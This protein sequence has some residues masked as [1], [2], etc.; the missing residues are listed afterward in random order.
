MIGNEIVDALV[1]SYDSNIT[2]VSK[3]SQQNDS[4]TVAI[5]HDK[6]TPKERYVSP[7]ARP[8]MINEIRII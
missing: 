6:E 3:H 1:K 4:E 8:Q 5:D 2:K 7:E